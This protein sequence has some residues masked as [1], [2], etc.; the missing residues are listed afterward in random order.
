[1]D[2]GL[3]QDD[4]DRDDRELVDAALR[5]K[6]AYA[7]VV[8]RYERVLARYVRRLLGVYAQS[9]ED[10]LQE[11]FIKAYINLND[12]DGSRPF[13]PW[14]YRIAHN[15][16]ISFLRKRRPQPQFLAGEDGLLLLERMADEAD[17]NERA[18]IDRFEKQMQAAI[19]E[20]DER[21]RDVLVLRYLEEKSYDDIGEIL[22]LPS[23]TVATR[24]RRGLQR[25]KALLES[26][27][28]SLRE[29]DRHE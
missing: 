13:G 19:S 3:V 15:E 8:N 18:G 23:G 26:S 21:Y 7:G 29:Y 4:L 14:I 11:T 25:M 28:A 2:Y 27:G 16:A 22:R 5:D 6:N 24:I 10:V 20:L 1:L 12:Y 9:A 17:L